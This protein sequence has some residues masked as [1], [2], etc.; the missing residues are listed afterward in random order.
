MQTSWNKEKAERY[1]KRAV[2]ASVLLSVCLFLLKLFASFATG[3]LA[4]L[5][6]L[7]DSLSDIVASFVSFFAVRIALKPASCSYRYGYLKAESLSALTQAAFIAGS[8][9]FVIYNGIDRF[10]NPITLQHTSI[11]IGVMLLS[12]AATICLILFQSYVSKHTNSLA[13]KADS[14]HY[15]VDILTNIG[16]ILSLLIVKFF[17]INWFDTVSAFLIAGYLIYYAYQIA[18]EAMNALMDKELPEE[19]R[20]E[21]GKIIHSTPEIRGFHDLRSRDL[22]G[23]YHFE[24]HLE[25]D[26]NLPL[27]E[28][29]KLGDLVEEKIKKRY[30][31][32]QVLIH[33]DPFGLKEKR[34]DDS[35]ENCTSL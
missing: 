35:L 3:S 30:P 16:I 27:S 4:I 19:V 24:I 33:Q 23:V 10:F 6:S 13:I 18:L 9:L 15:V 21:I 26:G 7:V 31:D 29:H 17:N 32:A 12:L 14:A 11:G 34:L 1:K 8:G 5:S 25:I 20:R 28:A 2:S 22:G